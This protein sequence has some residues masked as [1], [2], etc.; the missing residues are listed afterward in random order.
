MQ[1]FH[2]LDCLF[3]HVDNQRVDSISKVTKT[4][5]CRDR[6]RQSRRSG[7]Q[8]LGN[9]AGQ[10]GG[11][12]DAMSGNGRKYLDHA[13]HGAEQTQQW[14]YRRDCAERVEIALHFVHHVTAGVLDAVFHDYAFAFAIDQPRCKNLP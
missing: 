13:N 1:C 10:H 9:S 8:G 14:R 11:I 3:F 2:E 12:A 5:E 7:N 6:H 4:D